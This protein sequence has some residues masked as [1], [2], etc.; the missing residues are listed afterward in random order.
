MSTT[1]EVSLIVVAFWGEMFLPQIERWREDPPPPAIL[2]ALI[3]ALLAS[4]VFLPVP[5]GPIST[6]AG[7]ALGMWWGALTSCFGMSIGAAVAFGLA[8]RWGPPLARRWASAE[9]L[10]DLEAACGDHGLWMLV[11]TRPLPI[12]A[13]ACSLLAGTLQMGWIKFMSIV[14]ACNLAISIVYAYLGE[15]ATQQGWLPLALCLAVAAPLAIA[16][17]WRRRMR[18]SN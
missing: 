9:R 16:V 2:A 8:R 5:S 3:A 18:T 1:K 15:R 12:L 17:V 10:A 11:A 13:E 7:S 6:L 14:T 4:D